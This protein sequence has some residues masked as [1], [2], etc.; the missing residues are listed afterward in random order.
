M[1]S[2]A[3]MPGLLGELWDWAKSLLI[4]LG[5]VWLVHQFGFNFSIV[6]GH[7]MEPT[8]YERELLF[9]NKI[10]Y[11]FSA[12]S[13]GDVV[14]AKDPVGELA[15]GEYLVKR[16]VGLE[17]DVI[18]IRQGRLYVNGLAA[19]AEAVIEDGDYGPYSVPEGTVFVMGDNR[20]RGKSKDSRVYGAIPKKLLLGKA[21]WIMWPYARLGQR[22]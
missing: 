17:G 19:G 7:S 9:V 18:E 22:L 12:P 1:R 2:A 6:R 4:A 14:I 16:V 15:R 10:G 20:N 8:L 3:D 13:R 11:R 5:I 21:E